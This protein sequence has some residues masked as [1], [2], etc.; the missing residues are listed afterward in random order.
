[1][2]RILAALEA[3]HVEGAIAWCVEVE[4]SPSQVDHLRD[5]QAVAEHEDQQQLVPLALATD[6]ASSL[7]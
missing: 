4:I 2:H 6:P 7:D 1:M 3:A 5:P